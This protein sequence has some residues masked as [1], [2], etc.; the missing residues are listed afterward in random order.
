[1]SPV[2]R[3][4]ISWLVVLAV[5]VAVTLVVRRLPGAGGVAD[6]LRWLLACDNPPSRSFNR[7][8]LLIREAEQRQLGARAA[9]FRELLTDDDRRVV[10]GALVVLADHLRPS[11]TL[12]E[13]LRS[14][15]ADWFAAAPVRDK[16][17]YLPY[18]LICSARAAGRATEGDPPLA[19]ITPLVGSWVPALGEDD[20]RWIIAATLE[21]N[22]DARE[23]TQMLLF[24]GGPGADSV[25]HRLQYLDGVTSLKYPDPLDAD[26]KLEPI[27]MDALRAQYRL[28]ADRLPAMLSDPL[29]RVRWAAGR[30]LA[31]CGDERG[32]PAFDEWLQ[33]NRRSR[34][35]GEAIMI[36]LFGPE[37][38]KR[39]ESGGSTRQA[40]PGDN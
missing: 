38:R 6:E 20:Q 10:R 29:A 13:D 14:V 37:W 11:G 36:D 39:I 21:R 3:R 18:S 32:L 12:H 28:D 5:L 30:I 8:S 19:A 35:A 40:G 15:F 4:T 26:H 23:L 7:V 27:T 9:L 1:M 33:A 25:V 31:V 16:I 17:D 2:A 24:R 22:P 34:V